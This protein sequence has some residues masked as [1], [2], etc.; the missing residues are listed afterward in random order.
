MSRIRTRET[1]RTRDAGHVT[2][3]RFLYIPIYISLPRAGKFQPRAYLDHVY[4]YIHTHIGK[5]CRFYPG[6]KESDGLYFEFLTRGN[7][8]SRRNSIPGRVV[9]PVA[10]IFPHDRFACIWLS[11]RFC[12]ENRATNEN[13]WLLMLASIG[14]LLDSSEKAK[15]ARIPPD[16]FANS[17][18]GYLS[19]DRQKFFAFFFLENIVPL[20][21]RLFVFKNEGGMSRETGIR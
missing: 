10:D 18:P 21:S 20:R 16:F 11:A 13:S 8:T 14:P 17:Y 12:R 7:T 6:K 3:F 9:T 1:N 2:H 19:G 5:G 15:F 4:V